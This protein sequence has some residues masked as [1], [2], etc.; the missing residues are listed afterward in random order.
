MGRE[1]ERLGDAARDR[2]CPVHQMGEKMLMWRSKY[3]RMLRD[4]RRPA[5]IVCWQHCAHNSNDHNLGISSSIKR[6]QAE[7]LPPF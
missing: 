1:G 7:C 6:Q 4:D 2:W 5:A 3:C